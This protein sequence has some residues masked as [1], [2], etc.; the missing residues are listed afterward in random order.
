MLIGYFN[1]YKNY[2][3][4]IEYDIERKIY[5]GEI[6]NLDNKS[7]ASYKSDNFLELENYFHKSVDDYLC[8]NR[9]SI[10]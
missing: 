5:Y 6:V 8:V 10:I 7:C 1:K 9:G 2:L 3:G 4:T